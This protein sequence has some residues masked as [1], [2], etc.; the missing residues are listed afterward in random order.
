M[1]TARPDAI[2]SH[3]E[4]RQGEDADRAGVSQVNL[5]KRRGLQCR[6]VPLRTRHLIHD[7]SVIVALAG[8]LSG[9]LP[10]AFACVDRFAAPLELA[11]SACW[12]TGKSEAVYV[13]GLDAV[14]SHV[15]RSDATP[16]GWRDSSDVGGRGATIGSLPM[17]TVDCGMLLSCKKFHQS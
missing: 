12:D 11:V 7:L 14:E 10:L 17:C 5:P 4:V 16:T 1:L 13:F 3:Y 9:L 6:S 2:A 15:P 8:T